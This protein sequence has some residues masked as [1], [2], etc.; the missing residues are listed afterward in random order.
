LT[1]FFWKKTCSIDFDWQWLMKSLYFLSV[2]IWTFVLGA[3]IFQHSY[4]HDIFFKEGKTMTS[5]EWISW[6]RGLRVGS[7]VRYWI[8]SC[9]VWILMRINKISY[10]LDMNFANIRQTPIG[11]VSIRKKLIPTYIQGMN[12]CILGR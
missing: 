12:T 9:L 2:N 4:K 11:R 8:P 7:R 1:I 3:P 6:H 5:C 10:V